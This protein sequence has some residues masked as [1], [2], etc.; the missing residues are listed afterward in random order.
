MGRVP[1]PGR[2]SR[3]PTAGPR[4]GRRG[5]C[6][7]R[8]RGRLPPTVRGSGPAQSP[9]FDCRSASSPPGADRPS[10]RALGAEPV[11]VF[12]AEWDVADLGRRAHGFA[13]Q[14][15]IE[16]GSRRCRATPCSRHSGAGSVPSRWRATIEFDPIRTDH[17]HPFAS[18]AVA[19]RD[20]H[21][22][23]GGDEFDRGASR[24]RW[25]RHRAHRPAG[26]SAPRAA[27]PPVARR[28]RGRCVPGDGWRSHDP[29]VP[30]H[31]APRHPP[32]DAR[33]ASPRPIVSSAARRWARC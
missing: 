31:G 25:C 29:V 6:G 22:G 28:A 16:A 4:R 23:G 18:R 10:A 11:G 19:Q 14:V 1:R 21:T 8:R 7:A 15:G 32:P 2:P 24:I 5:R 30:P 12:R 27:P 17:A 9:Y 20:S 3:A 33:T 13:G 26:P